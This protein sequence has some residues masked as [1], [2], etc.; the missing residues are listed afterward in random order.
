MSRTAYQN[1]TTDQ[2]VLFLLTKFSRLTRDYL[3]EDYAVYKNWYSEQA[4]KAVCKVFTYFLQ[5]TTPIVKR[6]ISLSN[7][8][9]AHWPSVYSY[10]AMT[11][12]P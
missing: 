7:K 3:S 6:I 12:T 10:N 2:L 1:N 4:Q 11:G 8:H 5:N 9:V